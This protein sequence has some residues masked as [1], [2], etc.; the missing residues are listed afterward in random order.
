[1]LL[2]IIKN[3]L[4]YKYLVENIIQNID[5]KNKSK[6]K[7]KK[8]KNDIPHKTC[9][10]NLKFNKY[11]ELGKDIINKNNTLNNLVG[12]FCNEKN[13]YK[14]KTRALRVVEYLDTI[15][16]HNININISLRKI[17]HM[18]KIEFVEYIKNINTNI[19]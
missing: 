17:F 3:L 10:T 14:V 7:I 15:K 6:N 5:K 18:K 13:I 9:S 12:N 16:K 4:K 8:V 19:L 1:M 2:L 11:Y